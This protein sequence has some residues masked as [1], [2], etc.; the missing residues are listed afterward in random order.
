MDTRSL[1]ERDICTKLV[2]P[3]VKRAG[4]DDMVRERK[5]IYSRKRRITVRGVLV[6]C[7]KAKKADVVLYSNI[8]PYSRSHSANARNRGPSK[9]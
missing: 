6:D 9:W 8:T 3:A 7:G 2:Q 4:Q 1:T 5:E